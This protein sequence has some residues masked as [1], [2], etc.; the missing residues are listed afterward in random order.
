MNITLVESCASDIA[1]V[2][3][4]R[5]SFGKVS[6]HIGPEDVRLINALMR[7]G[8]GSPFEHTFFK[9]HCKVPLFVAREWMRHRI[10]SYNEMSLRYTVPDDIEFYYPAKD[11]Q[12]VGKAM[13]YDHV[14][15]EWNVAA[16]CNFVD[17]CE[18]AKSLYLSMITRGTAPEVA[19]MVLPVNTYTQFLWSVNARSMM[20]F[21]HLRMA[22]TAMQEIRE[23]AVM[24]NDYF[25][26]S[27]PVTQAAWD[28][29]GRPSV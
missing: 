18:D 6:E 24:V 26:K 8:H 27:M 17:Q 1:V 10:G 16:L 9:F 15:R 3:A 14:E 4:A 19:R 28:M 12:R 29:N 7:E 5:V 25:R 22:G 21:L 11:R 2:N 23:C 13:Q 20:N